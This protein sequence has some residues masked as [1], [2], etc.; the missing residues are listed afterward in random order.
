MRIHKIE[1]EKEEEEVE[2]AEI[3]MVKRQNNRLLERNMVEASGQIYRDCDYLSEQHKRRLEELL[4]TDTIESPFEFDD[5]ERIKQRSIDEGIKMYREMAG[6]E[7]TE[8]EVIN[9]ENLPKDPEL[10]K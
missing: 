9:E 2:F 10:R 4:T 3:N 1:Y 6:S 5:L 7:E 8:E